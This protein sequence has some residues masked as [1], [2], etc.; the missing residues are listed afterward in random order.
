MI[1]LII[2]IISAICF[3]LISPVIILSM[4]FILI[5]DG[6]PTIF[7]QKRLGI[8]KKEFYIYK[9]RTMKK[10]TPNIATHEINK[11][12]LLN[13]GIFLRKFKIDELPQFLN[14]IKGDINLVGPRPGL[15]SQKELAQQREINNIFDIKP[16]ITGL[17]Q[18]LG[19]DMSDPILLSKIDK[20]YLN[21]QRTDVKLK[22]LL[23]TFYKRYRSNI[24][25]IFKDDINSIN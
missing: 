3:L 5:E 6:L 16:G 23:A 11:N 13:V 22:I 2:K 10:N 12:K 20:I 24:E 7:T 14:Y 21:N 25:K 1:N 17:A 9:L 15:P 19:Y 18:I 8:N 4:I